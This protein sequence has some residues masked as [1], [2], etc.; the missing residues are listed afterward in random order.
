MTQEVQDTTPTHAQP[1]AEQLQE[2]IDANSTCTDL[3]PDLNN[4]TVR[5]NGGYNK[6]MLVILDGTFLSFFGADRFYMGSELNST[7]SG[8]RL[9]SPPPFLTEKL[10]HA[11]P[12]PP[13]AQCPSPASSSSS[14]SRD[15]ACGSSSTT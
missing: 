15:L 13:L 7:L 4:D 2:F 12:S 3:F 11:T 10:T 14:P 8:T 1:I 6:L 5:Q 9:A